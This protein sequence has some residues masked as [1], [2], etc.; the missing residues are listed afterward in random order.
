MSDKNVHLVEETE[1]YAGTCLKPDLSLLKSLPS[2]CAELEP[3]AYV[4]LVVLVQVLLSGT[5]F[6][7]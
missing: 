7:P 1:G 2:E 6:E 3:E 5:E 4:V